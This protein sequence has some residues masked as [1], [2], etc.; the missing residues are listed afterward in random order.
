[1]DGDI[2]LQGYKEKCRKKEKI[3][4]SLN[5]FCKI[6]DNK[7]FY[8]LKS[9]GPATLHE[10]IKQ[11]SNAVPVEVNMSNTLSLINSQNE[12]SI[13]SIDKEN[14]KAKVQK[15]VPNK[16]KKAVVKGSRK[17]GLQNGQNPPS[18]KAKLN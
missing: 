15:G 9:I 16:M 14:S 11:N 8:K 13:T 18:K 4:V 12:I 7:I 1:M 17:R 3:R 6:K 2:V 10:L 5:T